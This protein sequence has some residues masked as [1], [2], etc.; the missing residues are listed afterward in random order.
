M[1]S[2]LALRLESVRDADAVSAGVVNDEDFFDLQ[3][4]GE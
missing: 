3:L 4:L 1:P 2:F